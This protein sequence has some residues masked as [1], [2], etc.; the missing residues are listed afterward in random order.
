MS[1]DSTSSEGEEPPEETPVIST[2]GSW[3]MFHGGQGLLGRAE[4]HRM[5]GDFDAAGLD[6][7]D[8]EGIADRSGMR[9]FLADCHLEAARL[10]LARGQKREAGERLAAGRALIDETGYHRRDAE[11]DEIG[12]QL[13]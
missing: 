6:V 8:A 11:V 1:A 12:R 13:A 5:R 7:R 9:L 3:P 4:L 2:E 10:H